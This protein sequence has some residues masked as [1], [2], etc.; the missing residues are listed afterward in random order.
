MTDVVVPFIEISQHGK[1]FFLANIPASIVVKISYAAVRGRDQEQGAVQRVLNSRRISS[2]KDF[3]LSGGSFPN[4]IVMN[5]VR[6]DGLV[7]DE[8]TQSLKITPEKSSAQLIDGQ[9]RVAGLAEA[10][11]ADG[12]L[13]DI[14]LPVA[15]YV[16]LT[17][18]E[19]ANIFLAI[20]TEQKPVHRSLVFDLFA[21]AD[22]QIVDPA[23]ARARDIALELSEKGAP[24]HGM[25]K[26]P[27]EAPRKGGVALS[28]AVTTIKPL[29][30]ENGVFD[31]VS[32]STLENQSRAILNFF[33][34][35]QEAY[36]E[37]WFERQNAFM[38]ASGFSGAIEFL[39]SRMV[40]YCVNQ[41]SFK[42]DIMRRALLINHDNLIYQRE[43]T[44]KSGTEAQKFIFTRLDDLFDKGDKADEYDF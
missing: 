20:N 30:E 25:I 10:I 4:S 32:L 15:I 17:T 22:E 3:A 31:Q 37:L 2:I 41:K 40:P 19:C 16:G 24:Y 6:E 1:K 21:I 28:T 12:G 14:D 11:N 9:H 26:L 18:K 5:W 27:G 36:G 7:I 34:A 38:F 29:I 35:L 13:N 8:T 44:G 43:L 42:T 39:A 23:A 33:C